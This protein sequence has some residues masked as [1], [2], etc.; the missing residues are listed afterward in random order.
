MDDYNPW[1]HTNGENYERYN[2]YDINEMMDMENFSNKRLNE[3]GE[4]KAAEKVSEMLPAIQE[5]ERENAIKEVRKEYR[6]EEGTKISGLSCFISE[7]VTI[8]GVL[9]YPNIFISNKPVY[10]PISEDVRLYFDDTNE[11]WLVRVKNGLPKLISR[12]VVIAYIIVD[13]SGPGSCRA[14]VVFLK[15]EAKPLIFWDAIIEDAE[16]RRQTQFHQK[17]LSY[18]RKDLYHESFLRALSMCKRRYFLTLPT[19]GGWNLTPEG[20][21]VFVDSAMMRPEFEAL[22]LKEDTGEKKCNKIHNVFL[23]ISLSA[24]DRKFD[25][26]VADYHS[27]LPDALPIKIGTVISVKSRLLPFL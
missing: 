19:H 20:L 27:L 22:F 3:Y 2:T 18:A 10:D 26:V 1:E 8:N 6:L 17:G 21:R 5:R 13:A 16:L 25:D 11:R 4:E 23:D 12:F 7:T 24:T 15:G 14:C 9:L